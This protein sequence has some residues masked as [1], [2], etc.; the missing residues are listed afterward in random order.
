MKKCPIAGYKDT[1][2]KSKVITSAEYEARLQ[3]IDREIEAAVAFAKE[4]AFPDTGEIFRD[5]YY[6]AT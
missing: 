5:V 6:G 2:L 1:L 3:E 4:S